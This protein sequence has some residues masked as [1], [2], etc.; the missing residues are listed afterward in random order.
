MMMTIPHLRSHCWHRTVAVTPT[1]ANLITFAHIAAGRTDPVLYTRYLSDHT[2]GLIALI[3][4]PGSHVAVAASDGAMA[5][6]DAIVGRF[7]RWFGKKK[8]LH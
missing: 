3:G 4:E 7:V 5:R 2:E 6:A 8:R 1:C